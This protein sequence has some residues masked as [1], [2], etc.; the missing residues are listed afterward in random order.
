[1]REYL[2]SIYYDMI[3]EQQNREPYN[4]W[5]A[6]ARAVI[7]EAYEDLTPPKSTGNPKALIADAVDFFLGWRFDV[8]SDA[9]YLPLEERARLKALASSF[10]PK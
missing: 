3:R 6:L 5:L 8:W 2:Q 10:S 9:A 7:Q 1:M 4:P